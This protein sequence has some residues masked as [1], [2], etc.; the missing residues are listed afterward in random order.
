MNHA[1]GNDCPGDKM[2]THPKVF[3]ASEFG[4]WDVTKTAFALSEAYTQLKER[5]LSEDDFKDFM[6][7]CNVLF[8]AGMNPNVFT[9]T[10]LG[11]AAGNV[12]SHTAAVA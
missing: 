9:G 4:H 11:D 7:P 5:L 8:H 2:R 3:R 6:F 12:L 1:K 10:D